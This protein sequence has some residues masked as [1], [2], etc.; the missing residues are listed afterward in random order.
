MEFRAFAWRSSG[1]RIGRGADW[2][3]CPGLGRYV[4][5][6]GM[7]RMNSGDMGPRLYISRAEMAGNEATA[8]ETFYPPKRLDG[9]DVERRLADQIRSWQLRLRSDRAGRWSIVARRAAVTPD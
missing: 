9:Q 8:F 6:L 1:E 5:G 4:R 7:A 2:R 3:D